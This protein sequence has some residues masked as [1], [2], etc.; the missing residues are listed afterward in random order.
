MKKNWWKESVVYQIYPRSFKD[1]NG[2]GIGDIPGI[3]EKLDYLKELGITAIYLTPIFRSISNHKYDTMDYMQIDP[4]FGTKEEFGE[5]VRMAHAHGI[6]IVL[7][8]V[9]NHCSMQMQQFCDVME[10]GAESPYYDWFLIDGAY[11]VP[12]AMVSLLHTTASNC[13]PVCRNRSK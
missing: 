8:A 2:D 3:I 6:R 13:L 7:D 12:S 4:Q 11:P 10:K 1:S 5:L 9:F